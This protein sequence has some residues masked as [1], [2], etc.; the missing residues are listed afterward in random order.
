MED[1]LLLINKRPEVIEE[2]TRA[3]A[4][5][6]FQIDVASSGLE[7]YQKLQKTSYKLVVMGMLY[8][9]V[10][11]NK[12]LAYIRKSVP[13]TRCIIYTTR[14][15]VGQIAYLTNRMHVFR[16]FL[17]PADYKGEMKEAIQRGFE[18][19]DI[20]EMDSKHRQEE[21]Q[22]V[23]LHLQRYQELRQQE[24][25][26]EEADSMLLRI[27]DP[28][29]KYVTEQEDGLTQFERDQILE[30]EQDVIERYLKE[31]RL[32]MNGLPTIEVK[33]RHSFFEGMVDRT[34]RVHNDSTVV[35]LSDVF[36]ERMYI[37]IWVL[38]HR[39]TL[40]TKFFDAYVDI[41]FETSSRVNVKVSFQL[42]PGVWEAEEALPVARKITCIHEAIVKNL[43]ERFLR[44]LDDV[45][46]TY[47]L[48]FETEK[49]NIFEV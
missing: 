4:G 11:G 5:E 47:L 35:Q 31:N 37:C 45:Q 2:F 15:S 36:V 41:K 18:E 30:M 6:K 17:R 14:I 12:L 34:L 19:Y 25:K 7:G 33:L 13:M 16:I 22:D 27:F 44:E 28:V 46:I 29:L 32:P 40:L 9:D 43:S 39:I 48:G 8:P 20:E 10:D 42:P 24:L 49:E 26:Q 21:E 3:Y 38:V 1:R 23:N